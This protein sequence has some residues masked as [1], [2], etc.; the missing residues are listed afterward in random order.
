M[1]HRRSDHRETPPHGWR[2]DRGRKSPQRRNVGPRRRR[3][4]AAP[5]A[6]A[7]G[8]SPPHGDAGIFQP[9]RQR[10]ERR[11]VRT[12]PAEK[13]LSIREPTVDDQALLPVVH[14][15]GTHGAAAI[16]RLKPKLTDSKTGPVIEL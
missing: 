14:A 7:G 1:V 9:R 12:L 5:R 6:R 8:V 11:C 15:E 10:I 2:P 4:P 13:T 3:F 16:Y